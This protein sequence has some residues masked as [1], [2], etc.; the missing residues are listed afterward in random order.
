MIQNHYQQTGERRCRK[1]SI[2]WAIIGFGS[3]LGRSQ[4]DAAD[5][6]MSE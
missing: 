6:M 1:S 5:G 4:D 3:S 2:A